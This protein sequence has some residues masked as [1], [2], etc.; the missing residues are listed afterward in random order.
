MNKLIIV[1]VSL[2]LAACSTA[3]KMETVLQTTA[4]SETSNTAV[5]SVVPTTG[6]ASSTSVEVANEAFKTPNSESSAV[7][8]SQTLSV[9]SI[10]F[11]YDKFTV[12]SEYRKTLQQEVEILKSHP[13]IVV[14]LEGNADERGSAAYNLALGE[15]RASSVRKSLV[16]LGIPASQIKVVSYGNEKPRLTCH[17]EKCWHE[18]RRVDFSQPNS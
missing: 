5:Q 2:L 1:L 16:L 9:A 10:Y 13:N 14:T 3:P 8:D 11:D 18:N 7:N 15:K 6:S 17:E 4:T 12:K